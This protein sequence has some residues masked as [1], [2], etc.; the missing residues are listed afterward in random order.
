[1]KVVST[2]GIYQTIVFIVFSILFHHLLEG[3][4]KQTKLFK[5]IH[6]YSLP[7]NRL[8]LLDIECMKALHHKVNIVPIIAKAD[9]LTPEE[10]SQMKQTVRKIEISWSIQVVLIGFRFSIKFASIIFKFIRF[11]NV[12]PM[13]TMNLKNKIVS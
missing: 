11:L 4:L 1:M 10:L 12:I 6:P 5:T 9:A 2:V 7:F 13:K 8:K 3:L